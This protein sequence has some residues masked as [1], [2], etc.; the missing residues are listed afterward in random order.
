MKERHRHRI[1]GFSAAHIAHTAPHDDNDRITHKI[2]PRSLRTKWQEAKAMCHKCGIEEIFFSNEK[3]VYKRKRNVGEVLQTIGVLWGYWE[4]K[5]VRLSST[6]AVAMIKTINRL[7]ER[8]KSQRWPRILIGQQY[9]YLKS[10]AHEIE[11]GT[12]NPGTRPDFW[13]DHPRLIKKEKKPRWHHGGYPRKETTMARL[14]KA[15]EEA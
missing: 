6:D 7:A 3:L 5:D 13:E 4:S 9:T 15:L 1:T 14:G 11:A 2:A 8:K 12:Y 10:A